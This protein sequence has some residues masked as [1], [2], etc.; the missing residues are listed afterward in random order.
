M[1]AP[2]FRLASLAVLTSTAVGTAAKAAL[3]R[4]GSW[5]EQETCLKAQSRFSRYPEER[6]GASSQMARAPS[7][8]TKKRATPRRRK[9]PMSRVGSGPFSV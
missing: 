1:L 4:W 9:T 5:A 6:R 2:G 3:L 7:R 8:R